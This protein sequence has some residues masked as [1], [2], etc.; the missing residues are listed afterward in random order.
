MNKNCLKE[1]LLKLQ[2]TNSWLKNLKKLSCKYNIYICGG[3]IRSVLLNNA[4][5]KDID[6]FVDCNQE[7]FLQFINIMSKWGEMHYGQYG[8]PRLYLDSSVEYIDIV[9]F[10]NFIVAGKPLL[11]IDD[12]LHNFDFTANAIAWDFK[13]DDLLDPLNGIEDINNG[14]LRAVRLDFPEMPVSEDIPLSAV[15]VFWFRLLHYQNVLGLQFDKITER[16]IVENNHR[17]KD[18]DMFCQNFF[19]PSISLSMIEKLNSN[20]H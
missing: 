12:L 20:V 10:Y 2:S 6:I 4:E 1:L 17:M 7:E 13:D 3:Y 19:V 15:S 16:W 8:S 14:L 18:Y 11:S 5:S 9:P